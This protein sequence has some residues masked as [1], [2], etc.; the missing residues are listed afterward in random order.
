MESKVTLGS[1]CNWKPSPVFPNEYMVSSNGDVF[2]KRSGKLIK[3][4]TDK[5]GYLYYVLCVSGERKTVKAHR[6]TALAFI[7][8]KDGKPTVNHINGVRTDNRVAN[9]EWAT[10]KEQSNSPVTRPRLLSACTARDFSK[11]GAVRNFG[12]KPVVAVVNGSKMHFGSIR[13]AAKVLRHS[14]SKM[15][16]IIAGKRPQMKGA[17]ISYE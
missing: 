2:S 16:E 3:P 10:N 13:E 14:Y 11:M 5:Y 9:L 7:E 1:T 17:E 6:L 4:N 15:S 12:R 8:N